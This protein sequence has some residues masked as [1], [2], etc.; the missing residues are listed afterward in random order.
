MGTPV[1]CAFRLEFV[2][3]LSLSF[4][5]VCISVTGQT[6]WRVPHGRCH[7]VPRYP[8]VYIHFEEQRRNTDGREGD[9][10]TENEADT[11]IQNVYNPLNWRFICELENRWY[12][13]PL[14]WWAQ[15]YIKRWVLSWFT[16][17]T[18]LPRNLVSRYALFPEICNT[19][20]SMLRSVSRETLL[21][22]ITTAWSIADVFS[23]TLRP[24]IPRATLET[25]SCLFSLFSS[26]LV[27]SGSSNTPQDQHPILFL[28]G[29]SNY[30]KISEVSY[31][32]FVFVEK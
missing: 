22:A 4:Y 14:D 1:V 10:R 30:V 5:S 2:R 24:R 29:A 31:K 18:E 17:N 12:E 16:T 6:S 13:A 21:L 32:N 19:N 28:V 8:W 9:S 3:A 27:P 26:L 11:C 7:Y 15:R 25:S 20:Y 23:M